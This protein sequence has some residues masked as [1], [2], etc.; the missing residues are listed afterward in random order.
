MTERPDSA[1]EQ[2]SGRRARTWEYQ[3]LLIPEAPILLALLL[4][5]WA[6]GF[7][8]VVG[9]LIALTIAIFL[10]RLFLISS[11]ARRLE[12]AEY[13]CA[14]RLSRVALRI[15]PWS[16]DALT[17]RAQGL[18]LRGEDAAAEPILRRAAR[19][20]PDSDL[21]H[22]SLAGVLLARGRFAAG[23][24]QAV[25]AQRIAGGSAHAAQH[26]SWLALHVDGDPI[27][28]QRILSSVDLDSAPAT[29][30]APL[31]VTLAEAQIERGATRA[32]RESL[33]QLE[34]LLQECPIPQQAELLY[35]LGRLHSLLEGD[36]GAY[37]RRSVELDPHGRYARP[38][39]LAAME[40]GEPV[41]PLAAS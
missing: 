33:R 41:R 18:L 19:L 1:R 27:A 15:Y 14:D 11:A 4:I 3:L 30:G 12:Q 2:Q 21:I 35:H 31:L 38:A 29:L 10:L 22:S 28:A 23:R 37:F 36:G 39:W 32:G 5:G 8:P 40:R 20:A 24:E 6:Y 26:L 7:P 25:Y 17:L 16:A 9:A 34:D 13:V